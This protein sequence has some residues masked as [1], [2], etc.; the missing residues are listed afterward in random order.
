[1]PFIFTADLDSAWLHRKVLKSLR[2][3]AAPAGT[4]T[5]SHGRV[6][7]QSR[8]LGGDEAVSSAW[9]G[10]KGRAHACRPVTKSS[11]EPGGQLPGIWTRL[12]WVGKEKQGWTG[13]MLWSERSQNLMIDLTWEIRRAKSWTRGCEA[14][15]N[16]MN[17]WFIT[18]KTNELFPQL[19]IIWFHL[20]M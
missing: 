2:G 7:P 15:H 10:L 4:T 9:G 20:V 1:M 17:N 6:S 3:L 18:K 8:I 19:D 13:E 5:K 12:A 16:K 11:L 14:R